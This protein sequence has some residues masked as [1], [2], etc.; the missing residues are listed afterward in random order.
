[1]PCLSKE[2][3]SILNSMLK[4]FFVTNKVIHETQIGFQ[5][6]AKASDHMFVLR[7]LIEKYQRSL[8]CKLNACFVDFEKSI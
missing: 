1:M 7:T 6:K 4:K 8:N 3:N 2:F 5:P